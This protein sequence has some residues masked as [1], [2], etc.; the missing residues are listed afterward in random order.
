MSSNMLQSFDW[1]SITVFNFIQ[2]LCVCMCVCERE[3]E[4]E[5]SESMSIK[6]RAVLHPVGSSTRYGSHTLIV[7]R[8]PSERVHACAHTSIQKYYSEGGKT[9]GRYRT[10]T[11]MQLGFNLDSCI[12]YANIFKSHV[13]Y[14]WALQLLKLY[15]LRSQNLSS[16]PSLIM[17]RCQLEV[18]IQIQA[19]PRGSILHT[20]PPVCRGLWSSSVCFT[21]KPSV[22]IRTLN[23]IG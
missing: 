22:C 16:T 15:S 3:R 7:C 2:R 12:N 18:S 8:R 14:W 9:W 6:I 10:S 19:T 11:M 23:K 1:C 21:V 13:K 17:D 4:N 5:E 20:C